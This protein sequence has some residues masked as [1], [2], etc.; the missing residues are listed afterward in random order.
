MLG[1]SINLRQSKD[2]STRGQQQRFHV[3]LPH[4]EAPASDAGDDIESRLPP[5]LSAVS[6]LREANDTGH[7]VSRRAVILSHLGFNQRNRRRM[8][9][10]EEVGVL[11]P[12]FQRFGMLGPEE[13]H[14]RGNELALNS[15]FKRT[16]Y[17]LADG[18]AMRGKGPPK[19]PFVQ[20]RRIA[21]SSRCDFGEALLPMSRVYLVQTVDAIFTRL[22]RWT[23][24][25]PAS[26]LHKSANPF[27]LEGRAT[28][29]CFRLLPDG[30][31]QIAS[32]ALSYSDSG[33]QRRDVGPF[34]R[35]QA[36]DRP[37]HHKTNGDTANGIEKAISVQVLKPGGGGVDRMVPLRKGVEFDEALASRHD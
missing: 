14:S 33:C 29:V 4:S 22:G 12:S 10:T 19:E 5:A 31:V 25:Q 16:A 24:Q 15:V 21:Y 2:Q 3:A 9:W 37:D 30:S 8:V 13:R 1:Q 23:S 17:K 11:L 32:E 28:D 34:G 35:G 36:K 7:F 26:G 18:I 6:H 27:F 20:Q